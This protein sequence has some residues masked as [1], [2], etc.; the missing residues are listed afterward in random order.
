MRCRRYVF[1]INIGE[2]LRRTELN[3]DVDTLA[4]LS[5]MHEQVS[6]LQFLNVMNSSDRDYQLLAVR[7]QE[8][9][10]IHSI[11][12]FLKAVCFNNVVFHVR[13]K[14]PERAVSDQ[15]ESLYCVDF[16][17]WYNLST[18]IAHI[19]VLLGTYLDNI[20]KSEIF[21]ALAYIFLIIVA[22]VA[23]TYNPYY[24]VFTTIATV[25]VMLRN[26]WDSCNLVLFFS[27]LVVILFSLF[28]FD[29]FN[30]A[31]CS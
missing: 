6:L 19:G 11:D 2:I 24:W 27:D 7:G 5:K 26:V 31:I 1:Y 28:F 12:Q 4:Y 18:V 30:P 13:P 20:Y 9:E 23:I 29:K 22:R 16:F 10:V 21:L 14:Q 17:E 8:T 25:V 3:I 15:M